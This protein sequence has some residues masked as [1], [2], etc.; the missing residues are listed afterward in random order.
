MNRAAGRGTFTTLSVGYTAEW[1]MVRVSERVTNKS[2]TWLCFADSVLQLHLFS[3]K[4][5]AMDHLISIEL[6]VAVAKRLLDVLG[7]L[8]EHIQTYDEHMLCEAIVHS[9]GEDD[10]DDV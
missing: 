1:F 4:G 3:T 2:R 10:A 6:D 8:P 5:V 7:V 9:L